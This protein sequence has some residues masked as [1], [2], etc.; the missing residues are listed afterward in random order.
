[1]ENKAS[2]YV[3]Y[4]RWGIRLVV[5]REDIYINTVMFVIC[6]MMAATEPIVYSTIFFLSRLFSYHDIVKEKNCF[7][8]V[9]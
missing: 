5:E 6:L 2:A 9:F 3:D 7:F 8:R 1:M 4:F